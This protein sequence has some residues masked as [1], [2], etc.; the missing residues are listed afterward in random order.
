MGLPDVKPEAGR[1]YK[2]EQFQSVPRA[3][4]RLRL[5][6]QKKTTVAAVMII[7]LSRPNVKTELRASTRV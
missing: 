4:K 7:Y 2:R 6:E 1:E 5:L 3:E